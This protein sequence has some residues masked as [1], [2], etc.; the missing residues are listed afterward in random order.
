MKKHQNFPVIQPTN[1]SDQKGKANQ[2]LHA[3]QVAA[4]R[5]RP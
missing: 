1:S 3:S 5:W 4:M 2:H